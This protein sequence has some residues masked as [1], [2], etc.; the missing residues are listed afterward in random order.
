MTEANP[1]KANITRRIEN[2]DDTI[3]IQTNYI[4]T[5]RKNCIIEKRGL[6]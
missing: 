2:L 1:K 3:V 4:S 5:M 6:L